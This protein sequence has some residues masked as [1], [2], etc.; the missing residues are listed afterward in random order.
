MKDNDSFE[1]E[2]FN[3]DFVMVTKSTS[4][5]NGEDVISY[6]GVLSAGFGLQEDCVVF[7]NKDGSW[8][9]GMIPLP[10]KNCLEEKQELLRKAIDEYELNNNP[11]SN[12]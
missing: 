11:Q 7:R 3:G 5:L 10:S 12:S 2:N 4:I 8:Y 9:K 6:K 1:I